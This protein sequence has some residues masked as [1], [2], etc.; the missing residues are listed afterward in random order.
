MAGDDGVVVERDRRR[1]FGDRIVR[2]RVLRVPVSE[3]FPEGVT[4]AYH[5]GE[6]GADTPIPRYDNHHGIHERH[7]G[8]TVEEID[9]PGPEAR[10]ERFIE[11]LP[12]D[13]AP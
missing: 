10:F 1:D 8:A 7:A 2:I 5:F 9:F 6:K 11:E 12:D 4:Y 3:Q 13:I